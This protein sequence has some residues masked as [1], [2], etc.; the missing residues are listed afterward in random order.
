MSTTRDVGR[1]GGRVSQGSDA[2]GHVRRLIRRSVELLTG[3]PG[4]VP[5][6]EQLGTD[7]MR[8]VAGIALVLL[9]AEIVHRTG[10][11]DQQWQ[12][13]AIAAALLPQLLLDVLA[14]GDRE[15]RSA[16]RASK[17]PALVPLLAACALAVAAPTT[18][19]L[20][21]AAASALAALAAAVGLGIAAAPVAVKYA[22]RSS[23]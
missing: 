5:T 3:P 18:F 16:L 20:G 6:R 17:R 10:H 15:R 23:A 14:V 8:Q 21:N 9:A 19:L 12:Y 7:A 22:P 2:A 4:P 1:P 13:V 11:T